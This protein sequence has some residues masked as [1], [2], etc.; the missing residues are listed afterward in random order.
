MNNI[1]LYPEFGY[2]IDSHLNTVNCISKSGYI[3]IISNKLYTEKG[4]ELWQES[5]LVNLL[6][7]KFGITSIDE[8]D[9]NN[10]TQLDFYSYLNT[11][12][13]NENSM[14]YSCDGSEYT[15]QKPFLNQLQAA[16][17]INEKYNF[18]LYFCKFSWDLYKFAIT[19]ELK[20][21]VTFYLSHQKVNNHKILVSTNDGVIK[22]LA[23]SQICE[24][25]E[26]TI[27]CKLFD[28]ITFE[29]HLQERFNVSSLFELEQLQQI[30]P[31]TV[32]I[33]SSQFQ[34]SAC[35]YLAPMYFYL[36]EN[37][38]SKSATQKQILSWSEEYK[39]FR[40]VL[41][42][43]IAKANIPEFYNCSFT[44]DDDSKIDIKV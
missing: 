19:T 22:S 9:L 10:P 38:N 30:D 35:D 12:A 20:D 5:D 21:A 11:Q 6:Y 32:K 31:M 14:L 37:L 18:G 40:T 23:S 7:I 29:E 16:A 42:L 27:Q 44:W 39:D 28:V 33:Y 13:I 3:S 2:L 1:D 24:L 4:N 41:A 15:I 17:T 8:L 25:V 36:D 34:K 26:N 43:N